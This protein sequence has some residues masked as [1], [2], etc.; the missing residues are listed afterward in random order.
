MLYFR[1]LLCVWLFSF[2][3]LSRSLFP[4]DSETLR[5]RTFV[6]RSLPSFLRF[7]HL[8]AL[9][10]ASPPPPSFRPPSFC[11]PA[12]LRGSVSVATGLFFHG[13]FALRDLDCKKQK[14]G[15]S[16]F[17]FRFILFFFFFS[18]DKFDKFDIFV[19]TRIMIKLLD[20]SSRVELCVY[21]TRLKFNL[22]ISGNNIERFEVDQIAPTIK[23]ELTN[24]LHRWATCVKTV[25]NLL[26]RI[27]SNL[28]SM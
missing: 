6:S 2:S 10:F 17:I 13:F 15:G 19:L 12:F 9:R 11:N 16:N 14:K 1:L 8:L 4:L 20:D 26:G 7:F 27:I 3:L 25:N 5:A 22:I 24:E 28:T 21:F 23:S 18:L